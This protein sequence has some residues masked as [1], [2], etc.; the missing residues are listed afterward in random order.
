[1][2]VIF[3]HVLRVFNTLTTL[4][5]IQLRRTFRCLRSE[6]QEEDGEDG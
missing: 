4:A 5:D 1:M 2:H 6:A 3:S